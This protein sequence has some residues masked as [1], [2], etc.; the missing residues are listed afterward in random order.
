MRELIP[1]SEPFLGND[2]HSVGSKGKGLSQSHRLLL[3]HYGPPMISW[4]R[5]S[6]DEDIYHRRLRITNIVVRWLQ[7]R[8][9]AHTLLFKT[10]VSST[11]GKATVVAAIV[12]CN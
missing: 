2:S 9:L 8:K 6:M 3:K 4:K 11:F 1:S 5:L 10:W 12:S 7:C